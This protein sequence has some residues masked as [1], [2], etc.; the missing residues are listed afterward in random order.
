MTS[1]AAVVI[2]ALRVKLS[3]QIFP[4]SCTARDGH[5]SRATEAL[6][7]DVADDALSQRVHDLSREI[8]DISKA[9]MARNVSR[10]LR[11]CLLSEDNLNLSCY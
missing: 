5:R 6:A 9:G 1:S 10:N 4:P 7:D 11:V 3:T 8:H 2:G